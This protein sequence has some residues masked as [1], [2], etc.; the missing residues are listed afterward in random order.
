MIEIG[1]TLVSLDVVEKQFVCDLNA[2]KGAC[3]IHGD[4][5]APLEDGEETILEEIY[6]DVEPYLTEKGKK[7]IK[8][9]G[10][11]LVDS[12]G[13]KVTPLVGGDKECAYTIFENDIAFCGIEKAYRDGKVK[14]A[15]PVSCHLYPIRITNGKRN[16][17]VNYEKW[18]ICKPACACGEKLQVPV[19]KFVKNALIRKFGKD[20]YQQ[21]ELAADYIESKK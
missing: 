7:A 4:S 3:C 1:K 19:Y 10:K 5:G 20:W 16:V 15:K 6:D 8:K 18:D 2:C 11:W 17:L 12:D 21:L 13:D 14:W 9:Y